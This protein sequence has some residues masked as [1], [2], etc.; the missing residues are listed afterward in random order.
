MVICTEKFPDTIFTRN[1]KC[2]LRTIC[3]QQKQETKDGVRTERNVD[4]R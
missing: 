2:N 1:K 3:S 4:C